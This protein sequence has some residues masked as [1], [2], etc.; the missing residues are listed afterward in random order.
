[1]LIGKGG[2]RFSIWHSGS[3][4]D[5]AE[6]RKHSCAAR[7]TETEQEDSD[8][9]SWLI[10]VEDHQPT[11]LP[12]GRETPLVR[13]IRPLGQ[14]RNPGIDDAPCNRHV[15]QTCPQAVQ[16]WNPKRDPDAGPVLPTSRCVFFQA[17]QGKS[18]GGGDRRG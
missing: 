17:V 9:L 4:W 16:D 7:S 13:R 6:N 10:V 3:S 15:P 8:F 5:G 1:M 18:G 11:P 2:L 14:H 12:I